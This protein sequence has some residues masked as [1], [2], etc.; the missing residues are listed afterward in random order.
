METTAK[1]QFTTIVNEFENRLT[2][3]RDAQQQ[4]IRQLE[5]D[6]VVLQVQMDERAAQLERERAEMQ[7]ERRTVE[8]ERHEL[9]RVWA[10]VRELAEVMGKTPVTLK[11]AEDAAAEAGDQNQGSDAQP[12]TDHDGWDIRH[13]A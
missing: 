7:A 10:V 3:L 4:L 11:L 6:K 5:T 12:Q 9:N 8:A 13:A 2:E 1:D